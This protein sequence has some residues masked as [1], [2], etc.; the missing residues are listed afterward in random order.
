MRRVHLYHVIEQ[1][2]EQYSIS[3]LCAYFGFPRSSYYLW[4]SKGKPEHKRFNPE[5]AQAVTAIFDDRQK[6]Y[7]F[8]CYQLRRKYEIFCNPKTVLRYMRILGLKSPIR[9]KRYHSST[10]REIN[11][12]T[13]HVHYNVLARN[14]KAER[15]LQKL[16]TDVSYVYHKQGR[17][18][19]SVIKD[20][21]DNA[22]LAYTLSDFNDNKL[23]FDNIDQVFHDSWDSTKVCVL[24]S[25]Q[26][27]QYTNQQYLRK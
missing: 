6:G 19:L 8:I 24:H 23:V 16:T 5:L 25:D 14:F 7:R 27:F 9:K 20:C 13:R 2:K 17:M 12:K 18:F 3:R 22:I 10:Q 4:L 26:G 15:P 11:E 1:L 21:Y